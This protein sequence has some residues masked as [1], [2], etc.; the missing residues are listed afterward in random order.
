MPQA[1]L[2]ALIRK[3]ISLRRDEAASAARDAE[4]EADNRMAAR[5]LLNSG[6]AATTRLAGALDAWS[7]GCEGMRNDAARI[8]GG[9][10]DGG[11]DGLWEW[12]EGEL[13]RQ[14]EG[15]GKGITRGWSER[16]DGAAKQGQIDD[17]VNGWL[18]REK[19][20][21]G[22]AMGEA[23]MRRRDVPAAALR[24]RDVAN[25]GGTPRP[26][27]EVAV[28]Y[29]RNEHARKAV[30]EF[31]RSLSL[32][33]I[34]FTEAVL[35]SGDAAPYVG[36]VVK[37]LVEEVQAVVVILTGDEEVTL[38]EPL[39][40]VGNAEDASTHPQARPNVLFEAG[41]ALGLNPRHTVFVQIGPHRPFS[42]VAGRHMVRF[43]GTP[44]QR[45][46]LAS[47]L[48]MIGCPVNRTGTDWVT[49]GDAELNQAL[50]ALSHKASAAQ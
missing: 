9:S 18:F 19:Q 11:T 25:P 24:V 27:T 33:P 43:E 8:G 20:K 23:K 21:I 10:P 49:A 15:I 31:L 26:S 14:V 2:E 29:G 30:F 17:K 40:Q 22:I 39:R 6:M 35:R 32:H 47:R 34:E 48:E 3:A 4:R 37:K 12:V 45:N 7:R 42:D 36:D 16:H 1:E 13:T 44:E 38:R 5:G 50:S 46:D 41:L 28:V